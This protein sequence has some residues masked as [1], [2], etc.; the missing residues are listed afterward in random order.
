MKKNELINLL[1]EV[2]EVVCQVIGKSMVGLFDRFPAAEKYFLS[3][4]RGAQ[5]L[6]NKLMPETAI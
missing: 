5:D 2:L 1:L 6:I 4:L 3:F